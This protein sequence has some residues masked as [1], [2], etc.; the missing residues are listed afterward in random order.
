MA[1]NEDEIRSQAWQN[2]VHAEGTRAVFARRVSKFRRQTQFRDALGLMVPATLAFVYG[3]DWLQQ[4]PTIRTVALYTLSVLTLVQFLISAWS[5][6]TRWDDESSYSLRAMRDANSMR[7]MWRR[8]GLGDVSNFRT[9]YDL[10][11]EMQRVIDSHDV[12]RNVSDS[13]RRFGMRA[14]LLFVPKK[15]AICGELPKSSRVPWWPSTR[16]TNCGGN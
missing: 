8:I 4:Y 13:E 12:Q 14:G 1:L 9:S 6:L 15:C 7:D 10:A 2:V 3:T 16:C 11:S 5:I